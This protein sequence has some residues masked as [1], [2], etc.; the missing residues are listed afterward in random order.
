M[1]PET[2]Y[3]YTV[4]PKL[5]LIAG[6]RHLAPKGYGLALSDKEKPVLWFSANPQW[7]PTATKVLSTNGKEFHRPSVQELLRLAGLYRFRLDIRIPEVLAS[8]GIKLLPWTRIQ[9]V[10]RIAPIEIQNMVISGIDLGATPMHWWGTLDSV[11]LSL[12]V[13]GLMT[14]EIC[15]AAEIGADEVWERI[16]LAQAITEFQAR[17]TRY[18][19]GTATAMPGARSL[20]P[21]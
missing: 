10:S 20:T 4:G 18:H 8:M 3:H 14:L 11:P 17:G 12:E 9:T 7:E 13:S 5:A 15:R 19:Q 1:L 2:L 21:F 16:P 6:S